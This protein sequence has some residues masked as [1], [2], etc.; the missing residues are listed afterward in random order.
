M[1]TTTASGP[2]DLIPPDPATDPGGR[3]DFLPSATRADTPTLTRTV[4][5]IGLALVTAGVVSVVAAGNGRSTLFGEGYGYLAGVTGLA[6]LFVHALRDGDPDIRRAYGGLAAAL[7]LGAVV[8]AVFPAMQPTGERKAGALLLPWGVAAGFLSLAFFVPFS[9]HEDDPGYRKVIE[10]VLLSTGA[11]LVVSVLVAGLLVPDFLVGPGLV[12]GL[13]G[14]GFLALYLNTVDPAVGLGRQV[15]V[16]LGAVG[17][18]CGAV[19][20]G[21]SV[22]PTVLYDGPAALRAPDGTLDAWKAVA[23]GLGVL[24]ALGVAGLALA[25]SL[26][27]WLRAMLAVLGVALAGVLVA[28]CFAKPL[29]SAPAPFLVPYGLILAGLGVVYGLV[30]AGVASDAPVVVLTRRELTAYF[31]SPVAYFV[32]FGMTVV[33]WVAYLFFLSEL[34]FESRGGAG[35]WPSRSSA[36]TRRSAWS[37]RSSRCFWY[38]P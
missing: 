23:R 8:L 29:T 14:V 28:G 11:S 15:A 12:L 32:L 22:G 38:R 10:A 20:V 35:A 34:S 21:R 19:A 17:L 16:G 31:F 1:S 33:A 2:P 3:S 9:R 25:R 26:P 24:A 5:A 36:G 7:L 30:S 4:G 27:V 37:G 6:L 13:L 18:V